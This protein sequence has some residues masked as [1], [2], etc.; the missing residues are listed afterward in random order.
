MR[1]FSSLMQQFGRWSEKQ[2]LY[3]RNLRK[4]KKDNIKIRRDRIE[5]NRAERLK[6]KTLLFG[7][8]Q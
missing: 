3:Q 5:T 4:L 7:K 2:V 8:F 1:V 6:N